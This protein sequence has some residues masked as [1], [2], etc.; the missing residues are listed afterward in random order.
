LILLTALTRLLL[1]AL[2]SGLLSALAG[3]LTR[4]LLP[5]AALLAA[6]PTA[7]LVLLVGALFVRIHNFPLLTSPPDA[8]TTSPNGPKFRWRDFCLSSIGHLPHRRCARS[9][10]RPFAHA[11][12]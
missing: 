1:S 8:T 4:L 12:A 5:A 3:L 9:R 6:L 2:L 11:T 7:T 10:T